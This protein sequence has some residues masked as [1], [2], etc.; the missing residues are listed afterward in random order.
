MVTDQ[1]GKEAAFYDTYK[2]IWAVIRIMPADRAPGPDGFIGL[3]FQKAWEII[4]VDVIAALHKLFIGN[5]RGFGRLNQTLITL[6]PKT[7]EA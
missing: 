6:I 1:A 2:E 4:K 3:F 5:G 7:P